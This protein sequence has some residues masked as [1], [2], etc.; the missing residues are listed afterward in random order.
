ML[1]VIIALAVAAIVYFFKTAKKTRL[2][3]KQEDLYQKFK[4]ITDALNATAFE[5]KG[6]VI[7]LNNHSYNL[8]KEGANQLLNFAIEGN[9]LT[10]TWRF[11][12]LKRETKH[13][14][15]FHNISQDA[16]E[17]EKLALT[18][19]GEMNVII[20]RLQTSVERPQTVLVN[21]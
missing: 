5:N 16:A 1:Y 6:H 21:N 9:N 14:R 4:S 10:I 11:K 17:Q 19:I 3:I 20:E 8:Y 15:T 18:L 13:E 12:H 2:D 7:K